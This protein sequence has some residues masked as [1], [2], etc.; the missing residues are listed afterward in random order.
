MYRISGVKY[1]PVVSNFFLFELQ[2]LLR[3]SSG[4][5][6][7]A[8]PPITFTTCWKK[9]IQNLEAKNVLFLQAAFVLFFL[10]QNLSIVCDDKTEK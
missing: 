2:R 10:E 5:Q 8:K 9:V 1:N 4:G 7:T 6:V 3:R